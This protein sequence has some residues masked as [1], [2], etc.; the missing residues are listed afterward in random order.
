MRT[1]LIALVGLI[2]SLN[3]HAQD[4]IKRSP[5]WIST[6]AE[7]VIASV[8]DGKYFWFEACAVSALQM[9]TTN[10]VKQLLNS[11]LGQQGCQKI[12]D[13]RFHVGDR[14]TIDLINQNVTKKLTDVLGSRIRHDAVFSILQAAT[15]AVASGTAVLGVRLYEQARGKSGLIRST[16]YLLALTGLAEAARLS[17]NTYQNLN[18]LNSLELALL[19]QAK[20]FPELKLYRYSA[21][22]VFCLILIAID[23]GTAAAWNQPE[24]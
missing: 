21:R 9:T 16:G 13:L 8:T 5:L 12:N 22:S 18:T 10:N 14:E 4:K 7:G 11:Y 24:T 17:I 19:D 20:K 2:I 23:Q 6:E 1:L 3:A 15:V